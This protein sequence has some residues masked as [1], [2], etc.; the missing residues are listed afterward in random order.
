MQIVGKIVEV[1]EI[2]TVQGVQTCERLS[3]ALV[4]HVAQA[5]IVEDV[6]IGEGRP[7]MATGSSTDGHRDLSSSRPRMA[8]DQKL[9]GGDVPPYIKINGASAD[10]RSSPHVRYFPNVSSK[11]APESSTD[12]PGRLRMARVL[13]LSRPRMA[14][15]P[16][17][18]QEGGDVPLYIKMAARAASS[19]LSTDSS[20]RSSTDGPHVVR[21]WPNWC[22]Y[23]R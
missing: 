9:G 12:G 6:E 10:G 2:H 16:D 4:R 13:I 21:G 15:E 5:E 8:G 23:R 7:R 3:I 19:R 20:S 22:A 18:K 17:R 1:P 14:G 11:D